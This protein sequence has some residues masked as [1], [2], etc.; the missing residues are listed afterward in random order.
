[1]A[2]ILV[3]VL[4][5][6]AAA[7]AR[8]WNDSETAETAPADQ[9]P[10]ICVTPGTETSTTG[11][12]AGQEGPDSAEPSLSP[13]TEL[14]YPSVPPDPARVLKVPTLMFHH[15]GEPPEGA[16]DIRLG[17]TVSG[18]DLDAM[19]SYL[20]QAGYHPITQ[21]QLF[22]ALFY[23]ETLPEQPVML[24]FDDGYD[25]NYLVARPILQ[26][27]GFTATFYIISD[28]VGT[29]E[30]MGWPQVVEL[31]RQG[32]DIG[33]H[34]LD[35]M[36]LTELSEAGLKH[37][38]KDSADALAAQLG[39]P[40]YWLCY[41]AGKYDDNVLRVARESGYLL[42]STTEPGEN[43]SSDAPLELLRYRVRSDTGLEGFKE[44]VR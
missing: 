26:K 20:K 24:T 10:E 18:S 14:S 7:V 39:H 33:S 6:V 3:L 21:E 37:E 13:F 28:K 32:M 31:D 38:L 42:A 19:M 35:H 23:G 9:P 44:M 15:V 17:L 27:Y 8:S 16:D 29:P 30:Y 43:Q 1:M 25:D 41:P 40:V 11:G 36:D 12:T 2:I 22:K 4:V 34:T 5:A